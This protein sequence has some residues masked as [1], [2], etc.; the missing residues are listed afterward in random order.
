[1]DDV[2]ELV[3]QYISNLSETKSVLNYKISELK[4]EVEDC[5]K[6]QKD[7]FHTVEIMKMSSVVLQDLVDTV[8]TKN[9]LK[10][11]SLV[12]SALLS[13]FWD[14]NLELKIEQT[15]KRNLNVYRI[16]ILKDGNRG[17]IRTNG[18][19]IWSVVAAVMK[20]LCNVLLE[21]YP[22]V[23]FDESLSMVADKYIPSTIKFI[24]GLSESLSL[25]VGA[26]THKVS[27]IE[28]SPIVYNIDFAP[29]E[30]SFFEG[31]KDL[32]KAVEEPYIKVER[33]E[34]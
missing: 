19:G 16:T 33:L 28:G 31:I 30:E 12:N 3:E 6:F 10:I 29:K 17:T 32:K 11:E 21:R 7:T 24:K 25:A 34:R 14:M 15:V 22:F 4:Q 27:F 1:M 23:M 18:G 13:I 26:I 20:L 8:S 5:L 9:I 2:K